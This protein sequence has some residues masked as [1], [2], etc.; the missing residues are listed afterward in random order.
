MPLW[1]F[2]LARNIGEGDVVVPY[3]NICISLAS[4]LVPVISGILVKRFLPKVA[5][6][7]VRLVRPTYLLIVT[8]IIIFGVITNLFIFKIMA[9]SWRI[10]VASL[11]LPYV[12]FLVGALVCLVFTRDW[13]ISKTIGI[14]TGI[15]NVGIAIIV[16]TYSFPQPDADL[17]IVAPVIGVSFTPFPLIIS[18]ISMKIRDRFCRSEKYKEETPEKDSTNEM[19]EMSPGKRFLKKFKNWLLAEDI[20]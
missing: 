16:M 6:V 9:S 2:L 11:S 1:F 13:K 4:L 15:Q 10:V 20:K 8:F 17:G 18:F 19:T 14:E 5:K 12:G 7:L 3:T